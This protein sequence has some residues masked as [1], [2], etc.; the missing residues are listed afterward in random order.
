MSTFT[1][2][3]RKEA[4]KGSLTGAIFIDPSKA[5]DTVSH[6]SVLNKLPSFGISEK[7][8]IWFTNHL[9]NCT[10]VVQCNGVFSEVFPLTYGSLQGS[11][12]K[13]FLFLMQ[14]NAAYKVLKHSKTIIYADDTVI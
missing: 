11:I 10:Q 9:F 14:F 6:A 3:I 1:D 8:L 7:D 5:F 2:Y 4:D 13:P 12:I